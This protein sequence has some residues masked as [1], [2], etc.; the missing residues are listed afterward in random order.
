MPPL[1]HVLAFLFACLASSIL[2]G[3]GAAPPSR[4]DWN[5]DRV[6]EAYPRSVAA[7]MWPGATRAFQ[8]TPE[9]DLFNGVW[10]VHV[11]ASADGARASS[12]G[13]IAYQDRWCPV[14]RWARANGDVQWRY[15]AVVIPEDEPA[16]FADRGLI[17]RWIAEMNRR[18]DQEKVDASLAGFPLG[19]LD[20]LLLRTRRPLDRSPVDRRNLFVSLRIEA[21][22]CGAIAHRARSG[23]RFGRPPSPAP[24]VATDSTDEVPWDA[25]WGGNDQGTAALGWS[26]P[27]TEGRSSVGEC[28]LE[29][30]ETRTW[31]VILPVYPAPKRVLEQRAR[32]PHEVQAQRVRTYWMREMERGATFDLPDSQVCEATRAARVTLLSLRER[33]GMDWVPIGGPFHYR[34]IWLRDGVRAMQALSLWGYTAEARSMASSFLLFQW[35]HGPFLSQTGQL[36]G[37]GQAL[38]VFDQVAMRP[39]PAPGSAR[40]ARAALR[41]WRALERQRVNDASAPGSGFPGLLPVTDPHDNEYV[42]AQ[43]VGNDAWAIAGYRATVRLLRACSMPEEADSVER[44]LRGYEAAFGRA[45]AQAGRPDIPPSW[46]GPGEDWGNLVVGYPCMVL[47]AANEHLEAV[48][49]RYWAKSGGAGLGYFA[50][51]DAYHSYVGADLGTWAL[52][53]GERAAAD[54][55]LDAMMAWRSASGGSAET[56]SRSTHDFGTNFPPHPTTAAAILALV[57]NALIFDEG[58]DL[59]LTLGAREGWWRGTRIQRAPTRWGLINLSFRRVGNRAEWTWTPVPVWTALT[60]PPATILDGPLPGSY[61]SGARPDIVLVP[62]GVGSASLPVVGAQGPS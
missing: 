47:P 35:P 59:M 23:I 14:T 29:P 17:S 33:R 22:N 34:G 21:S 45:L 11:D 13:A 54:S 12:P 6:P 19:Q 56:F 27:N 7:L 38:W 25:C 8:V 40:F 4:G 3:H 1:A 16:A 20:V 36:D 51:F 5:P 48:A 32:V 49:R 37:T 30:G 57:R 62:P 31:R 55:V 53:A 26:D 50:L 28:V 44:S 52:L 60:L 41:G 39:A 9:G 2:G 24:F 43:L 15:E 10:W 58:P 61:R 18:Q 42:R 46:Q